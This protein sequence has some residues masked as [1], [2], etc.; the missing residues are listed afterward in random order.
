MPEQQLEMR[1]A[2]SAA[3]R[4][5]PG[6]ASLIIFEIVAARPQKIPE[7]Y[8]ARKKCEIGSKK[9]CRPANTARKAYSP[10]GRDTSSGIAALLVLEQSH[11]KAPTRLPLQPCL[12][13]KAAEGPDVI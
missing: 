12:M 11:R 3:A 4:M 7:I 1:S 8:G 6:R 13:R 10:F 9:T 5:S 2:V